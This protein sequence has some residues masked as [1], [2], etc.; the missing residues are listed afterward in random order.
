MIFGSTNLISQADLVFDKVKPIVWFQSNSQ[1][2]MGVRRYDINFAYQ[3]PCH[4]FERNI[5]QNQ[6]AGATLSSDDMYKLEEFNKSCSALYIIEWKH[7]I[8]QLLSVE[9]PC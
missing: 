5:R 3:S 6:L 7:E 2:S 4:L 9:L 1:V 8:D